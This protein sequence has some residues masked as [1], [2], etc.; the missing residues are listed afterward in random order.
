MQKNVSIESSPTVASQVTPVV[1]LTSS[2][3]LPGISSLEQL[4]GAFMPVKGQCD[5]TSK[6]EFIS[7]S[8]V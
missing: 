4:P 7:L 6:E 3:Q 2:Q 5:V 8:A 1:P